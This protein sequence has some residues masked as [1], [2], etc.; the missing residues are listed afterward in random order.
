MLPDYRALK[1]WRITGKDPLLTL[2]SCAIF[3]FGT[4]G[5][6]AKQTLYWYCA[7]QK[8]SHQDCPLFSNWT[9]TPRQ[10]QH[11]GASLH[12]LDPQEFF[13]RPGRCGCSTIRGRR[14]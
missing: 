11:P 10:G 14:M 5:R 12:T 7:K 2:A 1:P 3:G 9:T 8:G 6:R 13:G 4:A